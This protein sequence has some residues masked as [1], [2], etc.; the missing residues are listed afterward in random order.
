MIGTKLKIFLVIKVKCIFILIMSYIKI[1]SP[2]HI[3]KSYCLGLLYGFNLT[4][5][6]KESER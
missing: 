2:K 3:V 6:I 1:K 4:E 5:Q